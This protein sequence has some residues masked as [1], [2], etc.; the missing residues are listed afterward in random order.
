[1]EP[2]KVARF[3]IANL[4]EI[5]SPTFP[6]DR[7]FFKEILK[8][9]EIEKTTGKS[10]VTKQANHARSAKGTLRGIHFAP[11]NKIIYVTRGMVQAVIVDGRKGSPTFGMHESFVLGDSD[12]SCVFVPA[13]CGNSYLVLSDDAD[14][15]YLT[16]QE[17][18]PGL[19]KSVIWNDQR[20]AIEWK[21]EGEPVLSERDKGNA[22]FDSVFPH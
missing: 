12:R 20:L 1:M 14:Y 22:S 19:E 11:W 15:M 7:G 21:L 8:I 13:G 18:A 5:Y 17:W 9:A 4:L 10:F 6:D 2:V 3:L 16:D